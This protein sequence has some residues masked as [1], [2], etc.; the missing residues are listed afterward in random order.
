MKAKILPLNEKYY[1]TFIVIKDNY[2]YEH[3]IKL[4]NDCSCIPSK[5]ELFNICTEKQWINNEISKDGIYFKDIVREFSHCE[6]KETYELA[7]RI[8]NLINYQQE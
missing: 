5:R 4:W 8:V 7:L 1:G 2:G 6:S 3:R